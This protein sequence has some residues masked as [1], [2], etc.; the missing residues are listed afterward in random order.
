MRKFLFYTLCYGCDKKGEVSTLCM[1]SVN[2]NKQPR[3]NNTKQ[4]KM[5]HFAEYKIVILFN[6]PFMT[7]M[8]V[9]EVTILKAA[10]SW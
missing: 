8:D 5:G 2:E 9:M 4:M 6:L 3:S 1:I 7:D 10:F